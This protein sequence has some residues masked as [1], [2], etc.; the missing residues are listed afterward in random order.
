[1]KV[2]VNRGF[3]AKEKKRYFNNMTKE[4]EN[5]KKNIGENCIAI[6]MWTLYAEFGFGEKRLRRFLRG[7]MR[8]FK[9]LTDYYE[10]SL[11]EYKGLCEY[12]LKQQ[13]GIDVK[14]WSMYEGEDIPKD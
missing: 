3:T 11:A 1:M 12:K 10:M 5:I 9:N 8:E 4:L 14:E 13:L 7:V 6:T 2:T